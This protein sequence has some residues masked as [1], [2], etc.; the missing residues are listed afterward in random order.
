VRIDVEAYLSAKSLRLKR[1]TGGNVH[2][3]C[4]FC[5]EDESKR[6]RLYVQTEGEKAGLFTCFRCGE[7]G[8]INKLRGAF[9]DPPLDEDSLDDDWR[10]GKARQRALDTAADYYSARLF[11]T[12]KV[13]EYLTR[14]R[15]LTE[16]TIRDARLGFADGGLK[17]A[18]TQQGIDMDA[19]RSIG[20]VYPDGREFFIGYIT[21]PYVTAGHVSLIRGRAFA[22][23][24]AK[25]KTPLDQHPQLY[26]SDI[27]FTTEGEITITESEFDSL[28]LRQLGIPAVG[29]P[30]TTAWEEKWGDYFK[31]FRRIFVMFDPD[32]PGKKGAEK[33]ADTLSPRARIVELPPP[34]AAGTKF[35]PTE[36]YVSQ[37]WDRERFETLLSKAKGGLLKTAQDAF[38][39]WM[40]MKGASGLQTGYDAVDLVLHPGCRFRLGQDH[41]PHQPHAPGHRDQ[42]GRQSLV[43]LA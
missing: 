41:L 21:I 42:P 9:G 40:A 1:A 4:P 22:H 29:C 12:P 18:A 13:L 28:V 25:Y 31:E 3:A 27:T 2:L 30:G 20:L 32:A 37:G 23:E 14:E 11:E 39:E 16:E 38:D 10:A 26:G 8:G 17:L 19:L 7:S 24:G 33:V 36:L 5:L 34:D 6:G 15:G 35:D 43:H